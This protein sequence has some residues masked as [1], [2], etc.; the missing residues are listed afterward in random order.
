MQ[1]VLRSEGFEALLVGSYKSA[2]SQD[3]TGFRCAG[4][5]RATGRTEGES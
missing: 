2:G 4:V 5:A 1:A 3:G